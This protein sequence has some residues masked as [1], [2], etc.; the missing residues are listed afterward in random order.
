VSAAVVL[1]HGVLP[2]ELAAVAK[3]LQVDS[4]VLGK[5]AEVGMYSLEEPESFASA[6][7][8]KTGSKVLI[9]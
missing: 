9:L 2:E 3:E 6:I 8:A 1:G 4:I 5:P 7:E